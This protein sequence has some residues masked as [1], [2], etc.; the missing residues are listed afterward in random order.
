MRPAIIADYFGTRSFGTLN[1]LSM[2]IVSM[3]RRLRRS[4]SVVLWM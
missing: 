1:G 3:G 2:F 4:L